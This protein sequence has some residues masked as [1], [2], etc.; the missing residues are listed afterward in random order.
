MTA[1]YNVVFGPGRYAKTA[2]RLREG[3]TR[4]EAACHV[5]FDDSGLVGA[6]QFWPLTVGG[7]GNAALLGPLA[8]DPRRRGDGIA[9]KLMETGIAV[10]ADLGLP[11]VILVGDETYYARAGFARVAR[12]RFLMPGPVNAD[13]ILVRELTEQAADLRGALSVP[14]ATTQTS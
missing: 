4:I 7:S 11:A 3:N 10:C 9:F 6:V 14:R 13:R 8:I 12:G 2:E 1:L 5:A